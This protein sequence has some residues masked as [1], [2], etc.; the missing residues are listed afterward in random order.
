MA[1]KLIKR[2]NVT[3][4][5]P[6]QWPTPERQHYLTMEQTPYLRSLI[7]EAQDNGY[8]TEEILLEWDSFQ[9]TKPQQAPAAEGN[10]VLLADAFRIL[11]AGKSYFETKLH[12]AAFIDFANMVL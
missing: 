3:A 11:F 6:N 1:K 8:T 5:V 7:K 2:A 4:L 10:E 9:R 12:Y